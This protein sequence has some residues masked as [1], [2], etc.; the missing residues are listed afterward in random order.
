M[1]Y[2]MTAYQRLV[3]IAY[4]IVLLANAATWLGILTLLD[5]SQVITIL[6]YNIYFGPD[7]FGNWYELLWL[8]GIALGVAVLDFCLTTWLWRRDRFLATVATAGAVGTQVVTTVAVVLIL[9][10]NRS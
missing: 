4:S 5:H 2:N 10:I 8:P 3:V 7:G 6:H 9:M 1:F